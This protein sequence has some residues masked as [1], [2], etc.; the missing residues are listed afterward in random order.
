MAI[1]TKFYD[2]YFLDASF[3]SLRYICGELKK[4]SDAGIS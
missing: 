4:T 1:R 3:A 2:D